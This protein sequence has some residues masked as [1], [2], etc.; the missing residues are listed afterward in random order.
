MEPRKGRQ[1]G[2]KDA[3]LVRGWLNLQLPGL[4]DKAGV[5]DFAVSTEWEATQMVQQLLWYL[6]DFGKVSFYLS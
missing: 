3:G 6:T 2:Y 5:G 4:M 1:V